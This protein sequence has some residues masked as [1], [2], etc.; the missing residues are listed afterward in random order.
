MMQV[1]PMINEKKVLDWTKV[2]A[3][4]VTDT[5]GVT[6]G[7]EINILNKDIS[8]YAK[9]SDGAEM[10]ILISNVYLALDIFNGVLPNY[11]IPPEFEE[12]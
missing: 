10:P 5:D 4:L 3:D 1:S 9:Y 2:Q 11:T 7:V 12:E 6:F 8:F